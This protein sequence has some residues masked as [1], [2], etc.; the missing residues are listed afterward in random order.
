MKHIAYS[1]DSLAFGESLKR[2]TVLCGKRVARRNARPFDTSIC[3]DL[4]KDCRYMRTAHWPDWE[5]RSA[6]RHLEVSQ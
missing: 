4:C 1:S 2:T 5:K 3:D 6:F